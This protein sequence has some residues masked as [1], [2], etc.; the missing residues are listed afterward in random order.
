MRAVF[1]E[2]N[3]LLLGIVIM[4]LLLNC[5]IVILDGVDKVRNLPEH[6]ENGL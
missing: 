1:G 5:I 4:E 2:L 6:R 3:A